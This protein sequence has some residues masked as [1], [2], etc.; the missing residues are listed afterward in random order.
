MVLRAGIRY[1]RARRGSSAVDQALSRMS[2]A[3]GGFGQQRRQESCGI[4]DEIDV[5]AGADLGLLP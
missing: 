2:L 1:S 3:N 5:V 4:R